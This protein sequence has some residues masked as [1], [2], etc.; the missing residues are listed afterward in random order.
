MAERFVL[1]DQREFTDSGV[2]PSASA[3]LDFYTTGTFNRLDTFT[4]NALGTPHANPV[5]ADSAGRFPEIFL[6]DLDYRV[7]LTVDTIQ[8]WQRDLVHGGPVSRGL[9]ASQVVYTALGTGAIATDVNEYLDRDVNVLDFIPI[10]QRA[11]IL[12]KTSTF[13]AFADFVEADAYAAS[14]GKTLFIPGGKYRLNSDFKHIDGDQ[15]LAS[16]KGEGPDKTILEFNVATADPRLLTYASGLL[17][18]ERVD[19]G[20]PTSDLAL[21]NAQTALG[22]LVDLNDPVTDASK[23]AAGDYVFVSCGID[24]YDADAELWR[25]SFTTRIVEINAGTGDI[26]LADPIEEELIDD[27]WAP[28]SAKNTASDWANTTAYTTGDYV[29]GDTTALWQATSTGTSSGTGPADDTGVSWDKLTVDMGAL[30]GARDGR[31]VIQIVPSPV[32]GLSVSDL[33][34]E[35][36]NATPATMGLD[37]RSTYGCRADNVWFKGLIDIPMNVTES[38]NNTRLIDV[39]DQAEKDAAGFQR[40]LSVY[41]SRNTILS[42]CTLWGSNATLTKFPIFIESNASVYLDHCRIS[43]EQGENAWGI[44]VSGGH[45]SA[46]GCAFYGVIAPITHNATAAV[47]TPDRPDLSPIL[48]VR[49]WQG[50]FSD[51]EPENFR[52][53][54][55]KVNPAQNLQVFSPGNTFRIYNNFAGAY[56]QTDP[57]MFRP[58]RLVPYTISFTPATGQAGT[59]I[60]LPTAPQDGIDDITDIKAVLLGIKVRWT[61]PAANN[62]DID[63]FIWDTTTLRRAL[64]LA[65]AGNLVSVNSTT[66]KAQ[67]FDGAGNTQRLI[68]NTVGVGE[69][70]RLL[71]DSGAAA[72]GT[73]YVTLFL[74]IDDG[75]DGDVG[76]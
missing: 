17:H 20:S 51:I 46:I 67:K 42:R 5:V 50:N 9:A 73:V 4:D 53:M 1:T 61:T 58:T 57:L 44:N 74:L 70:I 3:T 21:L 32:V 75:V 24:I 68:E 39:I 2:A 69:Q 56:S 62:V 14:V 19:N 15:A 6:Q 38:A 28:A 49:T 33:T 52:R 36:I 13:D 55:S 7:V 41:T 22:H 18:P 10:A 31:P 54:W 72:G 26:V 8:E 29:Y 64:S 25:Y 37:F 63:P 66:P 34:I 71:Y 27:G 45:I 30:K 23:F 48:D 35:Q 76:A 65:K 47:V 12:A 60:T 16:W 43:Q 59:V 40:S 11:A